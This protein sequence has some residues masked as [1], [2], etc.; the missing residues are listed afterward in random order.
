[1]ILFLLISPLF[2][3]T[4]NE[5]KNA[6]TIT[7]NIST[8]DGQAAPY[9]SVLIKKT[10]HGTITNEK[11]NFEF[12]KIKPGM[13]ILSVSLA[14]YFD[15]AINIE[16]KKDDAEFLRIRLKG[17]YAELKAITVSA[18]FRANYVATKTSESMRLN[19][20]LL[21]LPQNIEVTSHQLLSDQGSLSMTEAI[22]TVSGVAKVAGGLNDYN[23]IIRG[24]DATWAVFRNGVGGYFWSQQEDV[25]MLE[26]IEFIKGPAGFMISVAQP[27]GIIN[28][29]TKQPVKERMANID[30]GYG[31]YNM[32]RITADLGGPI[33]QKEKFI[34]RINLGAHNQERAFQFSRAHRYFICAAVKYEADKNTSITAES[35]YMRGKTSG[36]N[37][38]VPSIN[39]KMF[40]LPRNFA[41]AD[42]AT[43]AINAKDAYYRIQLKHNFNDNWHLFSQTAY[44][45]G[46]W[47]GYM[48]DADDDLPVSNDTLYRDA[49][50]DDYRDYAFAAQAYIDGKIWTG[51][52]IEHKIAAGVDYSNAGAR[53]VLGGT[54]G[55]QRFGLNLKQ[56]QYYVNPDSLRDFEIVPSLVIR[57]GWTSFYLQ[58]NIKIA[59]KLVIILG[60]H[61]THAPLYF[62]DST[63][64]DYQRN[65]HSDKFLPRAGLTWLFSDNV[66]VYA[67]YDQCFWAVQGRNIQNKPFAPLTGDDIETGMKSYF[68]NKKLI[69]N[70][71]IY[72]IVKNHTVTADPLHFNYYIQTGQITSRGIDFDMTG[73]VAPAL[74]VN[75]NY[76]YTDAKITRDTD[77][78]MVGMKNF[79][80]PD[81]YGNLWMKYNLLHGK[82]KNLSFAVGFQHMGKRNAEVNWMPGEEIHFLP[83]YNLLDAA[84]SYGN[85]KFNISLNVYNITNINYETLGSFNSA[86]NEW[87]YTPGE[88]VNFRLSFGVSLA[89][90]EKDK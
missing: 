61:F 89:N 86:T 87:R 73:N 32:M 68:F 39:G 69:L 74:T 49:N 55:E 83:V 10:G 51:H 36:N 35:N 19:L 45:H 43:D 77:S 90:R 53:D 4:Q 52:Q 13:Y 28:N 27:G 71:S 33:D 37:T 30:E 78:T 25:A 81:H 2:V 42:G 48:L 3:F 80:T 38:D 20:P 40:S 24:T 15:S 6:G 84:I 9:V 1:M 65:T 64:P 16:V 72:D 58:D 14:G 76:S 82:L 31:S 29:I 34:Y 47:G 44:V 57:W 23:P 22:R 11:G 60:S 41:I 21:E 46:T 66:S 85:E 79:G 75:A 70:L 88:P 59:G 17:T 50:F 67:L 12:K 5:K 18:N 56:P 63:I 8:A 7:G 26:K 54:W 62:A